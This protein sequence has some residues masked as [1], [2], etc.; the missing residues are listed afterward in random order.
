MKWHRST[1][2]RNSRRR[3]HNGRLRKVVEYEYGGPTYVAIYRDGERCGTLHPLS[4]ERAI[5]SAVRA[6]I[7]VDRYDL[8]GLPES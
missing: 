5:A 3:T 4:A 2:L 6:G 1:R 8:V 7:S